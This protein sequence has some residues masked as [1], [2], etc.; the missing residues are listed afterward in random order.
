MLTSPWTCERQ[1]H[2]LLRVAHGRPR[3]G[4]QDGG[5]LVN[6]QVCSYPEE[7]KQ[8][9]LG[10]SSGQMRELVRGELAQQVSLQPFC[11]THPPTQLSKSLTGPLPPVPSTQSSALRKRLVKNSQTVTTVQ[12]QPCL[13]TRQARHNARGRSRTHRR[14]PKSSSSCAPTPSLLCTTVCRLDASAAASWRL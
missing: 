13:P 3:H 14:S 8:H 9:K 7:G 5:G 11:H 6:V 4:L 10:P 1:A 2:L 12:L